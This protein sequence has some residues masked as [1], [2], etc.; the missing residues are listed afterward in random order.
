MRVID[1]THI[2][3]A[4]INEPYIYL[5]TKDKIYKV[6][7]DAIDMNRV[8]DKTMV[9]YEEESSEETMD[10]ILFV[11]MIL[12]TLLIASYALYFKPSVYSSNALMEVKS[13]AKED[14]S[15]GDFLKSAFSSFANETVDKE[16]EILKTFHINNHALNKVN[17][18]I[19]YFVEEEYKKVEIYDNLPIEVK[20]VTILDEKIVGRVV[21]L[22]PNKDGYSLQMENSLK[23]RILHVLFNKE[24]LELHTQQIYHYG[25]H[26]KTDYFELTIEKKRSIKEP[27]YF[28]IRGSNRQIYEAIKN[29]LKIIQIN[30]CF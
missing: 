21:K 16:I 25:E 20:R 8:F 28:V 9:Y 7:K 18:Q 1:T 6:A 4:Y 5:Y 15:D 27:I 13:D 23:S 22:T 3:K 10:I 14:L 24:I 2:E 26:V 12:F 17:F 30:R 11:F 19:Q 29:N